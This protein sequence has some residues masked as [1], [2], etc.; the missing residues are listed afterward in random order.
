MPRYSSCGCWA[1]IVHS[2]VRYES[3]LLN[4]TDGVQDVSYGTASMLIICLTPAFEQVVQSL[5]I[6][7]LMMALCNVCDRDV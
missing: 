6:C 1:T 5:S 4:N 7:W 2:G 3:T